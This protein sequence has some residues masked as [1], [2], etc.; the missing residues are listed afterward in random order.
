MA[1]TLDT[2]LTDSFAAGDLPGL[3]GVIVELADRRLAETYF[4]GAD[5][6]WGDPLGV[7]QHGPDTL[8]DLRSITKSVVGLLYGIALARG[9]VPAPH[10]PLYAQFPDYSDLAQEPGRDAI[11]V[12]HALSMQMGLE[13]NEDLPYS[14]TRNSEIAME[15]A[16]DRYRY[17]LEQPIVQA[18]GQSW[19]YSGGATALIGKMISDGAGMPLDA[20]AKKHLFDPLGIT[21]F[22][23]IAGQDGV[24]SAASGLRLVLP[25]L[26]KI[27]RM[28]AQDGVY[29]GQQ[30]VPKDWLERSFQPRAT[31]D[32][33]TKYGYLWYL[34]GTPDNIVAFA[35]GNGGQRLTVQPKVDLVVASLA[36]NYN[37][38][39]AWRLP[40]KIVLEFVVPEAQRILDR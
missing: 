17:V 7:R 16:P 6:R 20:F 3:H 10:E 1:D 14:D 26:V 22:E 28:V 23:W 37:Q 9:E 38:P 29:E 30:I 39:E 15:Y 12:G 11:L 24:P 19:T 21:E 35:A 32:E 2:R 33:Y 4:E 8:H 34:G 31:L 40:L 36:G 18:P 25:D 5:E 13:W 27:G